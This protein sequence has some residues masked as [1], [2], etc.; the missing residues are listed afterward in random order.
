[1]EQEVCRLQN[2]SFKIN[3]SFSAILQNSETQ[4]YKFFYASNKTKLLDKPKLIQNQDDL[5]NLLK[6]F[7]S[8]KD[9]QT[10]IRHQRPNT[11]WVL[12]RIVNLQTHMFPI[13]YP[14]GNPPEHPYY[15]KNDRYM[16]GLEKIKIMRIN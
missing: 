7:L 11:K 9:F 1:M 15:I 16:F 6:F 5:N 10:H 14:P 12:E 3:L 4:E 13:T 2:H 8:A